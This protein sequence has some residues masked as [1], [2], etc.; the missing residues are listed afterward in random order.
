[1]Y[2]RVYPAV[3]AG[4]GLCEVRFFTLQNIP[5]WDSV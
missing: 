3:D 4:G 2:S 5:D 1:V